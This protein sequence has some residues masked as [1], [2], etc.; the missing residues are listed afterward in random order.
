ML[1]NIKTNFTDP[2]FKSKKQWKWDFKEI[3]KMY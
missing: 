3:D 2:V 1:T